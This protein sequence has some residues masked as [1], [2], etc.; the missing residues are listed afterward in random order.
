MFSHWFLF[1]EAFKGPGVPYG[2]RNSRNTTHLCLR[3][4]RIT[5]GR[6]REIEHKYKTENC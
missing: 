6:E 2:G 3:I 4:S 5:R 1:F